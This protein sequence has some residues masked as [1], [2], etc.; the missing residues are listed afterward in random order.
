[1]VTG[2]PLIAYCYSQ[3]EAAIEAFLTRT[4]SGNVA[5][6]SGP[7]R[8]LA[9]YNIGFG[10]VGCSGTGASMWGRDAL[11]EFSN[12]RCVI[13]AQG[14]FAKSFFSGPPPAPHT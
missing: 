13:R 11:R 14:G 7:Q 5:V 6:N 12:R 1:M 3:D 9:N 4:S 2:K 10:G 8:M